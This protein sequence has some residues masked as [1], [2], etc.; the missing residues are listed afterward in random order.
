MLNRELEGIDRT[1]SVLSRALQGLSAR[2]TAIA[3]NVANI[4]T[5]N[6]KALTVSF[7]GALAKA[8]AQKSPKLLVTTNSRH[9]QA[10]VVSVEPVV[11]AEA[12]KTMRL[13]GNSVDLEREMI[14]LVET[15]IRY[16]ALAE[17]VGGRFALLKRVITGR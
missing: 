14:S 17:V 16:N 13:D 1:T 8:I 10:P 7:E 5:P 2:Q 12:G 9:M 15:T 11:S 6:Y 4:N 3:S